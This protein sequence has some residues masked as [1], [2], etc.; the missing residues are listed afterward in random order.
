MS[1]F[2]QIC[3]TPEPGDSYSFG[4]S[5]AINNKYLAIGDPKANQVIIYTRGNFGQWT[6]I[7]KILPP[8]DSTPYK[9][10]RGFELDLQ[11]DGDALVISAYTQQRT[12]K[13]TN[14]ESF[15]ERTILTSTFY[16]RYLTRLDTETEVKAINLPIEKRSGFVQ[17]N[18]LFRDEIK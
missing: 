2:N 3:L 14:P 17:F 11:I 18:L 8:K 9:I 16:G 5:V 1:N 4:S 13:V 10:G 7:R 12:R 15:Q 6:R